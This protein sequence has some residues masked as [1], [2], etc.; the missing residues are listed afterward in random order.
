VFSVGHRETL[1]RF[2][3]RQLKIQPNGSGPASI[4]DVTATR[5]EAS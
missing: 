4:V 1:R 2:H 5:A 3:S